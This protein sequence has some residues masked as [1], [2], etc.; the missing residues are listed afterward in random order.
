MPARCG[1]RNDPRA[2]SWTMRD[3]ER[4]NARDHAHVHLSRPP[5]R[6]RLKTGTL[7]VTILVEG[8]HI[9]EV[10]DKRSGINPLWTPHWDSIE[11]STFDASHH[12]SYGGAADGPLL[13]GIMGHNL[14]LDIF[15]GPSPEE[16]AAGLIAHG[17]ASVVP[18]SRSRRTDPSLIA[19]ADLP[20]AGLRVQRR[21]EL[22][23]GTVEIT[24]TVT[25]LT[26][27]DRP[28]GWTQHVTL[29]PPF[30]KNGVTRVPRL[31]NPFEGVRRHIRTSG[32]SRSRRRVRLA[33]RT[34]SARRHRRSAAL[35][36][37]RRPRA[38]TPRT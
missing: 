2:V 11:P 9:A 34:A 10:L 20:L 5:C 3:C 33:T 26:A 38:P 1:L 6:V 19:R 13:A 32:L 24:E 17:E 37:T 14:C 35:H 12:S 8:G 18:V 30:L 4:H 28:V 22:R 15:G 27:C 29:G 7:R 25:N 36:Q 23:R 16:A 31:G 21:L